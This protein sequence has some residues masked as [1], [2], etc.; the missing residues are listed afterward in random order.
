MNPSMMATRNALPLSN[1][2]TLIYIHEKTATT[3]ARTT[4]RT[5]DIAL[6][7][8][9]NSTRTRLSLKMKELF[10]SNKTERREQDLA[11]QPARKSAFYRQFIEARAFVSTGLRR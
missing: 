10:S 8:P 3:D 6:S 4:T 1:P 5:T 9:R 2:A 7:K 11:D